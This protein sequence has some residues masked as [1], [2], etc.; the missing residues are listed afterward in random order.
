[1][2]ADDVPLTWAWLPK[3]Y[4]GALLFRLHSNLRAARVRGH[5]RGLAHGMRARVP[6]KGRPWSAYVLG[7]V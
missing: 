5:L 3:V 6:R 4:A 1:M 2:Q 7:G